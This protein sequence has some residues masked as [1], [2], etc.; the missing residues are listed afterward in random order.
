VPTAVRAV[1]L[2]LALI[3]L[4]VAGFLA[5]NYPAVDGTVWL[6]A[7]AGLFLL[8]SVLPERRRPAPTKQE[9]DDTPEAA[10]DRRQEYRKSPPSAE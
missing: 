2:A 6:L 8:G 9:E 5:Q 3:S 7:L 4:G 10:G 1:L